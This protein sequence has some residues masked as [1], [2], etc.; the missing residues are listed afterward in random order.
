M[1]SDLLSETWG[2]NYKTTAAKNDSFT[3]LTKIGTLSNVA[4]VK[5]VPIFFD[6]S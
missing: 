2:K 4:T 5:R 3:I 1:G 6:D